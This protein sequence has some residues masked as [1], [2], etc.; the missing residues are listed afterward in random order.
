MIFASPN[1]IYILRIGFGLRYVLSMR[2]LAFLAILVVLSFSQDPNLS[3]PT[4]IKAIRP[5]SGTFAAT[6]LG[7]FCFESTKC[8]AESLNKWDR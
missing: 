1:E 7:G 5:F 6:W 4:I 3:R 8:D 2:T